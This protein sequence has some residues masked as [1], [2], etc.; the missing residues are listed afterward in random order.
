[1][2]AAVAWFAWLCQPVLDN[3]TKTGLIRQ[4]AEATQSDHTYSIG[5]SIQLNRGGRVG[6]NF[7][8]ARFALDR[9]RG[10]HLLQSL[11][12]SSANSRGP[13]HGH[14]NDPTRAE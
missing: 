8:P 11:R 5:T 6:A 4:R 13:R 9:A 2:A 1:M 10:G 14:R 12:R 7:F 3:T